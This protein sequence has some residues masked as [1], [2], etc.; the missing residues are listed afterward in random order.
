MKVGHFSSWALDHR[1]NDAIV[2]LG[3]GGH[4]PTLDILRYFNPLT[5]EKFAEIAY[6]SDL[7]SSMYDD[8]VVAMDAKNIHGVIGQNKFHLE[9][10]FPHLVEMFTAKFAGNANVWFE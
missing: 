8:P 4:V 5:A 10:Y 2:E 1:F 6:A 9:P 7:M 3:I